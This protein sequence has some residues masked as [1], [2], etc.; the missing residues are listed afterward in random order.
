MKKRWRKKKTQKSRKKR[1]EGAKEEVEL[2]PEGKGVNEVQR[3]SRW[4]E[5]IEG[6]VEK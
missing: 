4:E 2:K 6:E 1:N 3:I 5:M